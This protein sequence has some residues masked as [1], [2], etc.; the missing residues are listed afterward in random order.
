MTPLF[1]LL[2]DLRECLAE[3]KPPKVPKNPTIDVG[4]QMRRIARNTIGTPPPG[5]TFK[6]K[7]KQKNRD[8]C[9]RDSQDCDD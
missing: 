5:R 6:D 8:A 9:R 3:G 4:Q 1:V 7:K 2:A